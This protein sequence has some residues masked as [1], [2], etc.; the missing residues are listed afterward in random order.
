MLIDYNFLRYFIRYRIEP[1]K[2]IEQNLACIILQNHYVIQI[3]RIAD[4][5]HVVAHDFTRD[6]EKAI[7]NPSELTTVPYTRIILTS[8]NT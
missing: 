5:E 4:Y 6:D 8:Q 3:V 2:L 1:I 7:L